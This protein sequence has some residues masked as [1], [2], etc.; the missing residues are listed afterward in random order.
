MLESTSDLMSISDRAREDGKSLFI[1]KLHLYGSFPYLHK[2][3]EEDIG[4]LNVL[5]INWGAPPGEGDV[6]VYITAKCR[7]CAKKMSGTIIYE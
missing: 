5:M 2:A 3:K 4:N 6:E 1:G 7:R